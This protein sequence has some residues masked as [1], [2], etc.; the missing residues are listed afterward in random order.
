MSGPERLRPCPQCGAELMAGD[1]HTARC[2]CGVTLTPEEMQELGI[3][4][5][6]P[7]AAPAGSG[8]PTEE[9]RD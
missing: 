1:F 4:P 7:G 3:R 2:A 8:H 5:F 6:R 9:P